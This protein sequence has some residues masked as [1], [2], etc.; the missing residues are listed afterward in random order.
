MTKVLISAVLA[1]LLTILGMGLITMKLNP[2]TVVTWLS[3][4][5]GGLF[6]LLLESY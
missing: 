2:F 3:V 5:T 6:Y 4:L 1:V